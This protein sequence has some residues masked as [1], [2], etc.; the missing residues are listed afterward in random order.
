MERGSAVKADIL[1]KNIEETGENK[2]GVASVVYATKSRSLAERK[3]AAAPSILLHRSTVPPVFLSRYEL[4]YDI[5]ERQ[6]QHY[7]WH[8]L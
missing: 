6:E 8:F 2:T 5:R 7:Y 3:L 4:N 1:R